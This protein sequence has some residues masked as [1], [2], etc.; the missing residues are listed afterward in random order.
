MA[1]GWVVWQYLLKAGCELCRADAKASIKGRTKNELYVCKKE[2][3]L[4]A[5]HLQ[6]E[7]ERQR[8]ALKSPDVFLEMPVADTSKEQ[9]IAAPTGEM[10]AASIGQQQFC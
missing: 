3:A 4:W 1:L 2:K 9:A 10:K 8:L 7:E 6:R 5:R